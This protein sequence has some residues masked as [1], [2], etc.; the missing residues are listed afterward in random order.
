MVFVFAYINHLSNSALMYLV[1]MYE[2]DA[3]WKCDIE[4]CKSKK[5]CEMQ[6]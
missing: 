1:Y 4:F 6:F 5:D 2:G 3:K